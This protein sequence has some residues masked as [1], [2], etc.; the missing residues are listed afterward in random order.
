MRSALLCAQVT[1]A[2]DGNVYHSTRQASFFDTPF[3]IILNT[4]VGGGWP[5]PP[6]RSTAFPTYHLVDYVYVSQPRCTGDCP[7][8][9]TMRGGPPWPAGSAADLAS[10]RHDTEQARRDSAC[11]SDRA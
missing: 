3:Y 5:R 7:R 1:W 4:A 11:S 2:L 6:D 10:V 8:H 9:Q